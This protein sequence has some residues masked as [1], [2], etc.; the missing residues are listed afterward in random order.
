MYRI[1]FSTNLMMWIV[2]NMETKTIH[3]RWDTSA[4][5]SS[6]ALDLKRHARTMTFYPRLAKLH[7]API[8]K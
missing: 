3:S 1:W 7:I 8:R 4:E 5:A 6:V 2:V